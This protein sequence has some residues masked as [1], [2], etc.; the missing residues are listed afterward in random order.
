MGQT[1][2]SEL[3]RRDRVALYSPYTRDW[4]SVQVCTNGCS[5]IVDRSAVYI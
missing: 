2:K 1:S 5:I 4:L 3:R